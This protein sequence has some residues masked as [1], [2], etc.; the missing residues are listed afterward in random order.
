MVTDMKICDLCSERKSLEF[1]DLGK[2]PMANKY[3]LH[4]EEMKYEQFF[5]VK[6][7]FCSNCKNIQLDTLVSREE[8]FED[9]YYLSSVNKALVAHY[10]AF[11]HTLADANFV[12]DVGSNDGISLKPL[13][14]MG[15]RALGVDPS[16]NVGKIANDAGFETIVDFFDANSVQKILKDYGKA[17]VITGLSMFSHLQDQHQFIE[18]VKTLL[19]DDG[20]FIVEVEYNLEML[21]KMS[22][23]RFYLDRLFYFS[24]TSFEKLF[25]MHGMYLQDAEVTDIHGGSLRVTAQKK[26]KKPTARVKRLM[27]REKKLTPEKVRKFGKDAEKEI[28][29][30]KKK[31]EG[32][33][34]QGLRVAGYGCPARTS[35]LT[36]FGDIGPDL[37]EFIVDDSPLKQGRFSPGKHIP[38]VPAS[39][40]EE[41]RPDVLVMFAYDY[42]D[43]IK[44][45]LTGEYRFL[46][47]IPP[48]EVL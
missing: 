30:L 27:A 33:K 7:F 47:P 3:P 42:F 8:M 40:L 43:D 13:K 26:G 37:I 4:G 39:H 24:V 41:H 36:N 14:E 29:A 28:K 10:T 20:R 23:E 16:I 9:Y 44:K 21:K 45:K 6:V 15:V 32:Y 48:R 2:Q 5:D 35:T 12:V 1:L 17:D 19:T 11:A 46:F 38:I 31:L 34:A 25:K 22:F 18:D